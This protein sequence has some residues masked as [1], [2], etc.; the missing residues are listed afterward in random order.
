MSPA[1]LILDAQIRIRSNGIDYIP[2]HYDGKFH[3]LVRL[4]EAL[5][6]SYN[7]SAIKVLERIGVESLLDRLKKLG[8]DSLNGN[9]EKAALFTKF[10]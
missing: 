6:C 3:G 1:T 2:R 8:F 4:R 9:H 10:R 5:A 7:I